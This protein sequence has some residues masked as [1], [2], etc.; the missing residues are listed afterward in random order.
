MAELSKARTDTKR[1]ARSA[2][3]Y[4]LQLDHPIHEEYQLARNK[5]ASAIKTQGRNH[6]DNW[7]KKIREQDI[8][9]ANR[10]LAFP[11]SDGR[12][13]RIPALKTT[14]DNGEQIDV[15]NNEEKSRLL[16]KVFFYDP[17]DNHGID[18]NYV[19][20]DDTPVLCID[21]DMQNFGDLSF[22]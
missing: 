2:Y 12:K 22:N 14:N 15:H 19:Y 7:L 21:R 8:W 4:R 9:T 16:H 20:P 5:Y 11:P 17:P 13:T 6:W 1:L 18:P 10:F 3:R